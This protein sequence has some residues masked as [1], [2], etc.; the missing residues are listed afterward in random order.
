MVIRNTWLATSRGREDVWQSRLS[1]MSVSTSH[2]ADASPADLP[3]AATSCCITANS[4]T[5]PAAVLLAGSSS[6]CRAKHACSRHSAPS[7]RVLSLGEKPRTQRDAVHHAS[8]WSPSQAALRARWAW[9]PLFSS[10][11]MQQNKTVTAVFCRPSGA[12]THLCK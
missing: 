5:I 11:C 10:A 2:Q 7:S 12:K 8:C 3:E 9:Q 1:S 6:S 4:S